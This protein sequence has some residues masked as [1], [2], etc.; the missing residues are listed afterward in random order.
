MIDQINSTQPV[1]PQEY[2][3]RLQ[4]KFELN[5]KFLH[6][7]FE[8]ESPHRM[9]FMSGQ[10]VSMT[11][12][13]GEHRAYSICSSPE[14]DYKFELL[15][16]ISPQGKGSLFFQNLKIGDRVQVRGPQGNFILQ[17]KEDEKELN[18]IATGSGVS[19]MRSMILDL[20]Q[21]KGEKRP[22]TLY[23]G[24]R[25]VE[26]LFWQDELAELEKS[27]SN[28]RFHPVLSKAI[29][30]WNLCRGHVTDCLSVHEWETEAGFY[31][32]GNKDMVQGT[33]QLLIESGVKSDHIY[34]EMFY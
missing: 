9:E 10:Y 31:L 1:K 4:D 22:I 32:C 17:D 26:D 16:D 3:A 14:Y 28:F 20:L 12:S 29:P 13:D 21:R 5:K 30:Q 19:P 25:F 33:K 34:H 18:F 2:T 27:F 15:I 6:L 23:W 24:L 11:I 8:L 7:I